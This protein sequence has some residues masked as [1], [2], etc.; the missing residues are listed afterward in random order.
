MGH[1]AGTLLAMA[2]FTSVDASGLRALLSGY[3][4]GELVCFDGIKAGIE[5]TNYFV[6]TS[7][8]RFVLTL[9]EKLS[10]VELPF[11]LGL[12]RHLSERGVA[13]PTPMFTRAGE[14]FSS[15]QGK[16]AAF[17]TRLEGSDLSDPSPA[18]CKV[19]GSAL[20]RAHLAG[21]DFNRRLPNPRGLDWCE[22]TAPLVL[23]FLSG[24]AKALLVENLAE[25]RDFV[26]GAIY[27]AC[28]TGPIHA[29]LFRDNVLFDQDGGRP[30][31][32]G[33]IDFYFAGDAPWIYDLAIT[34]NDWCLAPGHP[35]RCFDVQRLQ[36][37]LQGY[38]DERAF[39]E[40]ERVA[41]PMFLRAAALRFWL[42]RLYDWHC[43]RPAA[44]LRPKD[45]A[46]FEAMLGS[47][48]QPLPQEAQLP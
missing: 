10:V 17:V 5:N 21:Q 30:L 46:H 22:Q 43:P 39:A 33:F 19:V 42:S 25:Q 24:S 23:S 6:D 31:L 27:A 35:D 13:C 15:C 14:L 38:R 8:G 40:A 32:G 48:S 44:L 41:W 37:M 4:L 34:V 45:P 12:M 7:E 29:D 1:A 16:P 47:R 26:E 9:F 36:A 2:V 28:P 20:A 18:A 11:Y 3:E